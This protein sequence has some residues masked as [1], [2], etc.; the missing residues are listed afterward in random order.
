MSAPD[1]RLSASSR[2]LLAMTLVLAVAMALLVTV[3]YTVTDQTLASSID[4]TLLR[5]TEAYSAAMT[6]APSGEPLDTATRTYLKGRTGG[7]TGVVP[8]LVVR[9]N[10]RILSNSNLRIENAVSA[11]MWGA[12]TPRFATVQFAGKMY[13]VLT[14]PV[15][16]RGIRSG[17]FLAALALQPTE[18]TATRIA[19]IL[20]AAGFIAL[21]VGLMLSYLATKRALA[22]LREMAS[23]AAQIT[24][25]HL[26]QRLAYG[27]PADEL[28]SLAESINQMLDR[29]EAAFSEQRR[30]IADAS[31]ELRT[32]VAVIR[33]NVE[34]LLAGTTTGDDADES[35][36][37]IESESIRMSR[38]LDELLALARLEAGGQ[39]RMQPLRVDVLLEEV[40]ARTKMLGDRLVHL[41]SG[42][43]LWIH[44]DPDLLD[45][46]LMNLARNAVAHTQ[47][48]GRINFECLRSGDVVELAITDDGPGI[49]SDDVE[50]VFDRFYRA[51]GRP[52]SDGTTGAGLGLAITKQLIE[53]HEGTIRVENAQPHGARFVVRLP[54]MEEPA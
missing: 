18:Q 15:I 35:L 9:S 38:L 30:F 37:M 22:P 28:G 33:G 17:T 34:L 46:A 40:T 13:R 53:L 47:D 6:S 26:D 43:E 11:T 54:A 1:L 4:R 36:G 3:A 45:G 24:D 10:G 31:H 20:T 19:L 12:S 23:S 2:V 27:G 42:C 49:P 48:G 8:L 21:A 16:A 14:V 5:E 32:P 29:L 39:V 51:H 44:A 7:S 41:E 50:R 25:A 52:R